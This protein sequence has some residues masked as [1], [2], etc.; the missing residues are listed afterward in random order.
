MGLIDLKN[1]DN[2]IVFGAILVLF[3][4]MASSGFLGTGT[5]TG[6]QVGDAPVDPASL[7]DIDSACGEV[8]SVS[9][10]VE[11]AN[12]YILDIKM[13]NTGF[14]SWRQGAARFHDLNILDGPDLRHISYETNLLDANILNRIGTGREAEFRFI[15]TA[16]SQATPGSPQYINFRYQMNEGRRSGFLALLGLGIQT[17]TYTPF[18]PECNHRLRID[19]LDAEFKLGSTSGRKLVVVR[20]T[21]PANSPETQ[22]VA[23]EDYRYKVSIQ[24]KGTTEFTSEY[25]LETEIDGVKTTIPI[26]EI[27]RNSNA[28]ISPGA[29]ANF[30]WQRF[31]SPS[32]TGNLNM[33]LQMKT[34]NKNFGERHIED[35]NVVPRNDNS[36]CKVIG[37]SIISGSNERYL[38]SNF[39]FE[40]TGNTVWKPGYQITTT[41]EPENNH[42]L[43]IIANALQGNPSMSITQEEIDAKGSGGS[44]NEGGIRPPIAARLGENFNRVFT[45]DVERLGQGAGVYNLAFRMKNKEGQEFGG[46]CKTTIGLEAFFEV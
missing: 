44:R 3:V 1:K 17:P 36:I 31:T 20:P 30:E 24:N 28:K 5:I 22:V 12:Q 23:S 40:N 13:R 39:V 35:F 8:V 2:L 26:F 27:M 19:K 43:L 18:G 16:P 34:G 4:A 15:G 9:P 6:K 42:A 46:V 38:A 32:S 41:P 45:I 25:N 11:F 7:P 37:R 21:G 14:L 29:T 33:K 10:I